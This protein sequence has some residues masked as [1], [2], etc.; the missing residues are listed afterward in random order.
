MAKVVE[1]D[2]HQR[3]REAAKLVG[4][5]A[6]VNKLFTGALTQDDITALQKL[7]I[8]IYGYVDAKLVYWNTNKLVVKCTGIPGGMKILRA[9]RGIYLQQCKAY[10]AG[11]MLVTLIPIVVTYPVENSY[12]RSHYKAADYIPINTKVLSYEAVGSIAVKN[13][14]GTPAFY[15]KFQPLNTWRWVPNII[16]II[17]VL[18][19]ILASVLWV[20]LITIHLARRGRY[21]EGLLITIGSVALMLASLYRYGLP[22]NLDNLVLFSPRLYATNAYFSSLGVL[23]I[24]VLCMLWIGIYITRNT[25][26]RFYCRNISRPF[27]RY[28]LAFILLLTIV[29]YADYFVNTIIRSLVA[30]S[31]ISFDVN[32]FYAIDQYTFLGLLTISI[33]MGASCLFIYILNIQLNALIDNALVKYLS[34]AIICVV[35]LLAGRAEYRYFLLVLYAWLLVYIILLDVKRL[36][37]VAD[38]LEPHMVLWAVYICGYATAVLFHFNQLKE[39]QSRIVFTEQ[40]IGPQKDNV[41]EYVFNSIGENIQD[42]RAV[43]MFFQNPTAGSRKMLNERFDALYLGGQL[44]RYQS[45]IYLYGAHEEPLFNKDTTSYKALE[46]ELDKATP[47]ISDWLFYREHA[48]DGHYY[49]AYIKMEDDSG[50]MI[51]NIFIDITLKQATDATVYP[52]LL[53]PSSIQ[54]NGDASR[55]SYGTYINKRLITQTNDYAF[56]VFLGDTL[57]VGGYEFHNRDGASELW[58]KFSDNKMVVVAYE[59][60]EWLELITLFCY[61]FGIQMFVAIV[62]QLYQLLLSVFNIA[63]VPGRIKTLTLRRRVHLSMLGV[64]LVS[65]LVIGYI[66]ISFFNNEYKSSNVEKLEAAMQAVHQSVQQYMKQERAYDNEAL[67]DNVSRS[68]QFKYFVTTLANN[69]EVD[70]NVFNNDGILNVTSQDDIYDRELLSRV[71]RSDAYYQLLIKGKSIVI[72]NEKVGKLSYLSCYVPLR[73]EQ[74][75]TLGYLNVPF[76]SSEKDLNYQISNIVVTLI[77]LYAFIFLVSSFITVLITRWITRS[78]NV[79]IKQ[80]SRLN[81]QRNERIEWPYDDEIGMLVGEYNN[82]VRKVEEN[83]ILLA[84]SERESAWREMARQVAHEIKNPLTPMKLNIQ[85]LQQALKNNHPDVKSLVDK[86]TA[87]LVEQMD[88]LAYIASEFSNFAKMPEARAEE[89]V[90]SEILNKAAELYANDG[91]VHVKIVVDDESLHIIAD[92][93]QLIRVFTNILEN[94]KQAIP[95]TRK[96][97]IDIHVGKENDHV[98]IRIT[99]NGVGMPNDVVQK[100][101]QPYF[102]TKSSGTGLG[103]A[104]TR[105]IIEFWKGNIW[106]ETKE[107]VGT[108]FFITLPLVK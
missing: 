104:M 84:Q 14:D 65:F 57:K 7:P 105:K 99:D 83:A 70:I 67:F 41:T 47:T 19:A 49:L 72:Q 23:L 10:G 24:T 22:F 15:L 79:I 71:M 98:S 103:L 91:S 28:A 59:Q 90:P 27:V 64:V 29:A 38:L 58:Y 81:L 56:P 51:G 101:F 11:R 73:D 92:R 31:S 52:E 60:K 2:W 78:F 66:T 88:N 26:Y 32:R 55:Y 82:M 94:A 95:E 74:G 69:Q 107:G 39:K 16:L 44:A 50:G 36:R 21:R 63:A 9:E 96:G 17:L 33:I 13:T 86:V 87:S 77:N 1:E 76:F 40:R 20:H 102:T 25:P 43:R 42:D 5:T 54:I 80:F 53:Q 45:K 89:L 6:F 61:L 93:S 97:I 8:Y 46:H 68:I 3:E 48:T 100:I 18:A 35:F 85:Y 106:F 75:K 108:T 30:D 12:L 4:D 62:I 34:V 37:P